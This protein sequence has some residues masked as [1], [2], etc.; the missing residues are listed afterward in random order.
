M[1]STILSL[2]FSAL[3]FM[4]TASTLWHD[5][6]SA[7]QALTISGIW[8]SASASHHLENS[9]VPELHVFSP[10][11]LI[12]IPVLQ[13]IFYKLQ[14][15]KINIRQYWNSPQNWQFHAKSAQITTHYPLICTKTA[16]LL[17]TKAINFGH[18]RYRVPHQSVLEGWLYVLPYD[19]HLPIN[20]ATCHLIQIWRK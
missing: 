13:L 18:V 19:L 8:S 14:Y 17:G 15:K 4:T 2:V 3:A 7:N 11:H 5:M 12:L 6:T 16:D 10:F 20:T 9:P 1:N